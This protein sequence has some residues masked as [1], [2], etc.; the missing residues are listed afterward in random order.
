MA[1]G[2]RF[3][4]LRGAPTIVGGWEWLNSQ[5]GRRELNSQSG[6]DSQGLPCFSENMLFMWQH[7]Y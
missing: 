6:L 7:C 1:L 4:K 3:Q 2:A 5:R